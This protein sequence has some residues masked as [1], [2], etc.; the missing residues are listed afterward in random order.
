MS[1]RYQITCKVELKSHPG[2]PLSIVETVSAEDSDAA[3][4]L[5][6]LLHGYRYMFK[7]ALRTTVVS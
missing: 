2:V 7:A 6:R 3:Y 5:I 4:A 1:T